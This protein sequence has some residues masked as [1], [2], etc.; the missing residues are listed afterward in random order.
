MS[1]N[2]KNVIF[3]VE[4]IFKFVFKK[5]IIVIDRENIVFNGIG[6]LLLNIYFDKWLL[7]DVDY[8]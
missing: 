8:I 5:I 4:E 1:V 6:K 2:I 3:V 7:L